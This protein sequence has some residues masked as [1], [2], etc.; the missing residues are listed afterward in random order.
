MVQC[1]QNACQGLPKTPCG[2]YCFSK[3]YSQ[4]EIIWCVSSIA[5]SM[6]APLSNTV[7]H[8][9]SFRPGIEPL[10]VLPVVPELVKISTAVMDGYNTAH[11]FFVLLIYNPKHPAADNHKIQDQHQCLLSKPS[12][13]HV[14]SLHWGPICKHLQESQKEKPHIVQHKKNIQLSLS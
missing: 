5:R 7:C 8:H 6:R 9:I 10:W 1:K 13:S 2:E 4:W 14:F 11:M 3:I 12:H